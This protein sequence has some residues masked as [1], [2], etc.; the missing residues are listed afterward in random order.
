MRGPM[1]DV[2]L[3][4]NFRPTFWVQMWPD[5]SIK[6]YNACPICNCYE[7]LEHLNVVDF[8]L[9][10]VSIF[11][12]IQCD[13]LC[14]VQQWSHDEFVNMI[15]SL[16]Q[17]QQI[18]RLHGIRYKKRHYDIINLKSVFSKNICFFSPLSNLIKEKNMRGRIQKHDYRIHNFIIWSYC[19]W[20]S[21]ESV[22][23]ALRFIF[24][25]HK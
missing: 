4:Q 8:D 13:F 23:L 5:Q 2:V 12:W 18:P 16:N 1:P 9:L 11:I 14:N 22:F 7:T 25:F 15:V 20:N 24:F 19:S 17:V 6:I 10:F 3:A 21:N